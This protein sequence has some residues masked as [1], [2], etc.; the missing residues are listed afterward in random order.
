MK[1]DLEAMLENHKQWLLDASNGVRAD[2]VYTNLMYAD[3]KGANLSCADLSGADLSGADLSGADLKGADLKG[4]NLMY[5]DLSGA[6][7][8]GANLKGA[9]LSRADLKIADLSGANLKGV[10]LGGANLRYANLMYTELGGADLRGANLSGANLMCADLNGVEVNS[11]TSF[12][13]LQCPESGSFIAYKKANNCIIKLLIPE[14]AL[15]SSATSR[16]CR[17]NKAKVLEITKLDGGNLQE[18]PSDYDRNF[19]YKTG[20]IVV[21][22]NFDT[23]RWNECSNGIHFFITIQEAI[24][25]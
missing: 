1:P 8:S 23:N 18:V 12:Y 20:E 15:R 19:I 7:L 4:A 21:V 6:D 17:A 11:V 2:L 24:D 13:H 3:L 16:K 10:D 5:A 22:D 14:D 25:Y 9:N